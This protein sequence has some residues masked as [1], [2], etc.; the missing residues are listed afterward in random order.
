M[1]TVKDVTY[2]LLRKLELTTIVGN[3]G[4]TEETFLKNFP[5]DFR[6]VRAWWAMPQAMM[7]ERWFP[8]AKGGMFSPFYADVHLVVNWEWDGAEIKNNLNDRGQVRS[9]VWMLHDTAANFF[10]RTG[11]IWPRRTNG[12]SLRVMPAGCI[13]ADKG[14]SVFVEGDNRQELLALAAITKSSAFGLLVSL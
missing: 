6:F 2:D 7:P 3:P 13:F 10:F 8:F 5:D 9:N 1:R 12:F 4:S 11:L 14:P